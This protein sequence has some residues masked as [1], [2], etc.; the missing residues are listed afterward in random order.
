[1]ER[2]VSSHFKG[3]QGATVFVDIS[4]MYLMH[5]LLNFLSNST[6]WSP[7][8]NLIQYKSRKW[9]F[10]RKKCI[11]I[12]VMTYKVLQSLLI[13]QINTFWQ[14]VSI[15]I[16]SIYSIFHKNVVSNSGIRNSIVFISDVKY[17]NHTASCKIRIVIA[18]HKIW[19]YNFIKI[20][21][22]FQT[23]W[24]YKISI[25]MFTLF[26]NENNLTKLKP[27]LCFCFKILFWWSHS[28]FQ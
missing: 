11:W 24:H 12:G 2:R 1:M 28:P 26:F 23:T 25:E 16:L 17:C 27:N 13:F 14:P 19:V 3:V 6:V 9:Y 22:H 20:I 5:L 21:A 10:W 18:C 7:Q 15:I 8:N 4:G